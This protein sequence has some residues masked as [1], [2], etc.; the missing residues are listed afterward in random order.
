MA[1][2]VPRSSLQIKL[3]HDQTRYTAQLI[4]NIIIFPIVSESSED[5]FPL[6]YYWKMINACIK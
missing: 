2:M 6:L 3:S 4:G 5:S 1:Q